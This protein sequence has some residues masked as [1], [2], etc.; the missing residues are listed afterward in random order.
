M[1]RRA[2]PRLY[3]QARAAALALQERARPTAVQ[4]P[5]AHAACAMQTIVNPCAQGCD[6][7]QHQ[8]TGPLQK[9]DFLTCEGR[10]DPKTHHMRIAV[11]HEDPLLPDLI[12]AALASYHHVCHF[13]A[14]DASLLKEARHETFDLL[15]ADWQLPDLNGPEFVRRMREMAGPQ[16]P[17]LLITR[18]H[19]ELDAIDALHDGADDFMAK[20]LRQRELAARVTALLRRAY[21]QAMGGKLAFGPYRFS[22]E[23]RELSLHSVPLDLKNREYELAL[24]MFRNAGRLLSRAHL[25]EVVWGELNEA[26]SRSLDTHV[27][28][29]R[30][31]LQLTADNGYTITAIYGTGYRLD[32][33]NA[34]NLHG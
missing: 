15:I 20:P 8:K 4:P 12:R 5:Q 17:I 1:P 27:S 34:V 10:P 25:R 9:G 21:P 6:V 29:L 23:R 3:K 22:P 30:A 13:Y 14:S 19:E 32:S 7:A 2:R 31:K 33:T 24:F 11:L 26:P 16:L 18:R 28:R